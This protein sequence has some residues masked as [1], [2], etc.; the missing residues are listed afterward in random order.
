MVP[1]A[2][3]CL[4]HFALNIFYCFR[5]FQCGTPSL[6]TKMSYTEAGSCIVFRNC[7]NSNRNRR[8]FVFSP[9]KPRQIFK[10]CTIYLHI[11]FVFVQKP[12][13]YKPILCLIGLIAQKKSS[14]AAL[15]CN[16]VILQCSS[17]FKTIPIRMRQYIAGSIC[18]F[19]RLGG[20]GR[21]FR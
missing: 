5:A 4:F 1:L 3:M 12:F 11:M 19:L 8:L 10:F 21:L 6:C 18:P 14:K 13:S 9:G 17:A 16:F 7:T 15:L 2:I 20:C